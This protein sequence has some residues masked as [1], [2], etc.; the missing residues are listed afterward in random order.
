ML[1]YIPMHHCCSKFLLHYLGV[2][3]GLQQEQYFASEDG[4]TVMVC[5][6]LT[7]QTERDVIVTIFT[8]E[9]SNSA[10]GWSIKHM[11]KHE[12]NILS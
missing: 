12:G 5:A 11:L 1:V 4:E 7:G 6:S 9:L 10:Q 8:N 2:V 3:V